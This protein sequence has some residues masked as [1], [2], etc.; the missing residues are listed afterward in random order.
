[1][2]ISKSVCYTLFIVFV[3]SI[4]TS[5][6]QLRKNLTSSSDY[7]GSIVKSDPSDGA[8]LSNLFNMKMSH[9]YSITMGSVG[10]RFQNINMYTNTMQ[11]FFTDRL[12]G[13]VDLSLLH[14][15]F[16]NNSLNGFGAQ[17]E[18][19]FIIRN[20]ELNYE[21]SDKSSIHLRFN[22]YPAGYGSYRGYS[23]YGRYGFG[24]S[25]F[26]PFYLP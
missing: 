15:P 19:Q 23:P 17:Q 2:S 20:A 21:L 26:S 4:S 16:S 1:M 24:S 13:R 11:F 10:G 25:S 12:T 8:N 6:A 18:V 22:Q 9:S 7:T 14:S 3:L 5:H